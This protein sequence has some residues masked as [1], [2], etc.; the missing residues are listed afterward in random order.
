MYSPGSSY[1]HVHNA[2]RL[3][4]HVGTS[5]DN[6]GIFLKALGF[7][8]GTTISLIF[9]VFR[10]AGFKVD[11]PTLRIPQDIC[12]VYQHGLDP[13][14]VCTPCCSTCY[15][16]YPLENLPE[17]CDWRKSPRSW[18]CGTIL[19]KEVRHRDGT[20]KEV[21]KCF[22]AT[23]SFESWLRFF[24][25]RLQ[26]EE[27]LE[28]TFLQDQACQNMP[29]PGIMRDI[30]DSPAWC[31]LEI[32]ILTRYHL[33][34]GYYIDWF[35]PFT[36]KIAGPNVSCGAIIM[37][38]LNLPIEVQFMLENI[39]I[40]GMI[41]IGLPNVWTTS[42]ILL[43]FAQ[44]MKEFAAPGKILR[45]QKNPL[46]VHV[47]A[48][49]VPIIA[50]LQAICK[51]TGYMAVNATLFCNWCL[52]KLSEIEDLDH[53]SWELR[54][55]QTVA[56]QARAWF[57]ATTVK[58]KIELSK[59]SGVC[60]SPMHDIPGWDPI[61][62]IVLGWMHNWLEGILMCHLCVYWG[63]GQ[64]KKEEKDVQNLGELDDI[65][66]HLSGSEMSESGSELEELERE[67]VALQNEDIEM[68]EERDCS[69]T[70]TQV[71]LRPG[72]DQQDDDDDDDFLDFDAPGMLNF[73]SAELGS[74]RSCIKRVALLTWVAQPPT[75]LG[76]AKHGKL[77]AHEYLV[78]FIAI[79]PLII[80]ELWWNKGNIELALLQN[81]YH[82]IACTDIVSS[83][84]T[85]NTWAEQFT[86]Q[87]VKYREA[88][89]RLFP[90]N[91]HSV[92]NQHLAMHYEKLLKFWGPMAAL[93]EF[94]GE[95]MNG[96]LQKVKTNRQE[97]DMPLTML[98]Q[99]ARCCQLEAK[100]WILQPATAASTK[101]AEA[102]S[103]VEAVKMLS[104]AKDLDMDDYQMLLHYQNS[105]GQSWRDC[106][107]LP[108]PAGALVLPPVT[109]SLIMCSPDSLMKYGRCLSRSTRGNSAI[110][111]KDPLT[112][113]VLTGFID[114]IWEMPLENHIQ[115]FIM[116]EM[117]KLL[118]PAVLD[119]T[120]FPTFPLPQTTV[121]HAARSN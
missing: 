9:G 116:V 13:E 52:L 66:E 34:F 112:D 82:L 48:H 71:G 20:T 93:S 81:F 7:I 43:A 74:I 51:V 56:V 10:T 103:E 63:I 100:L 113:N 109:P 15:K 24:L 96:M 58:L 22:C 107:Q 61:L 27:Q 28:K 53:T 55:S 111:F 47:A 46:G 85:S 12:T 30:Q 33:V 6:S 94:L 118:P 45:T 104:V 41:P 117:H 37:Y 54:D 87:Y 3:N 17:I 75:N 42:H 101:A 18:P 91:F 105:Q 72:P 21:P 26:I 95:R 119:K 35:N 69:T 11:T 19:W 32:F 115:T 31:N 65:E 49:M 2:C 64:P 102:L 67:Q 57:H 25:S 120:P 40:L 78:L 97:D 23:P 5:R 108:H 90:V 36:N 39:F 92:P 86:K 38:C 106:H 77:K 44:V 60:W 89:P 62:H 1:R 84:S 4:L 59:A 83:F 70:P 121:V 88:L 73:S 8:I 99:L 114:E 80:P 79:F 98:R 76:E 110:Q 14:I 29:R 16:P 50:D 68:N